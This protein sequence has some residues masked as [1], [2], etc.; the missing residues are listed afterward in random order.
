MIKFTKILEEYEL[1]KNPST[2]L[3]NLIKDLEGLKERL[4]IQLI[5][6]GTLIIS[7]IYIEFI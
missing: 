5:K 1:V 6:T 7:K 3:D 4:E 2:F